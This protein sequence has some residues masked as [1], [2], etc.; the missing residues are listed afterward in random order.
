MAT[1]FQAGIVGLT[2]AG[3]PATAVVTANVR[4]KTAGGFIGTLADVVQFSGPPVVGNW[5]VPAV[6]CTVGGVRA[7][8]QTSQGIAYAPSIT[9]LTPVGPMRVTA[10]DP[11]ASGT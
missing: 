10:P 4:V 6:R 3:A 11:R 2:G 7:I 9:G 1:G 5:V 8:V